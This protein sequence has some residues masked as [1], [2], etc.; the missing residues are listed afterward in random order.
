ML[1]ISQGWLPK[2]KI[3]GGG[4]GGDSKLCSLA[5]GW[6]VRGKQGDLAGTLYRS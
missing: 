6:S 3:C 2:S 4:G 5:V 1:E